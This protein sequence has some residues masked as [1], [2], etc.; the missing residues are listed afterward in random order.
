MSHIT[1]DNVPGPT[2]ATTTAYTVRLFAVYVIKTFCII[3]PLK[4]SRV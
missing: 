4:W 2:P 1:S 3:V